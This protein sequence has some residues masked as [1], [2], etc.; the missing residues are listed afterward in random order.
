VSELVKQWP[1]QRRDGTP[2]D[3]IV[4]GLNVHIKMAT[5]W[6]LLVIFSGQIVVVLTIMDIER[7]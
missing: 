2:V 4:P 6:N 3:L 1:V 5:A 7:I